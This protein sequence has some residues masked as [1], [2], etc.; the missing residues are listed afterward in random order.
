MSFYIN[1][2][3]YPERVIKFSIFKQDNKYK[4]VLSWD[5]LRVKPEYF[6]KIVKSSVKKISEA[7]Q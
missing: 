5:S 4:A 7:K 3:A 1:A 2:V 6:G